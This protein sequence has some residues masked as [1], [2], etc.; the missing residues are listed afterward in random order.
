MK[1]P[2]SVV[3]LL[4][5]LLSLVILYVMIVVTNSWMLR[6]SWLGVLILI[7]MAIRPLFAKKGETP[8]E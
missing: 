6:L 4:Y 7:V 3:I 5:S 8:V 1:I 2:N